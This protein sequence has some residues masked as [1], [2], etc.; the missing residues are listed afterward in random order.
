MPAPTEAATRTPREVGYLSGAC[1]AV[2]LLLWRQIGGFPER[3]F[4]YGDDV[5][6]SLQLRLRGQ[7][8]GIEPSALVEHGYE[9]DKGPVKWRYLE[10]SRGAFIIRNYPGP[11]LA[12]LLPALVLTELGVLS[13]SVRGGWLGQKLRSNLD[14]IGWLPG[15][16]SER[17]RIQSRR[18]ISASQFA[19]GLTAELDSLYLEGLAS[20]P[21]VRR[22]VRAYWRMVR[23]LI[24]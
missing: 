1:L 7:K 12:A 11:L 2:P 16:L 8:I 3:L 22:A 17:R 9:F 4:M 18:R 6:L 19:D 14:L 23:A 15:L 20:S 13:T 21:I 24:R 5:D 10:R